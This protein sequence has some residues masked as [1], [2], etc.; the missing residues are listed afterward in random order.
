MVNSHIPSIVVHTIAST[1]SFDSNAS[2]DSPVSAL[3]IYTF[4]LH[5]L[6]PPLFSIIEASCTIYERIS[7]KVTGKA[8]KL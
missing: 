6:L 5:E 2:I 1:D 8:N 3:V 4:S 7:I